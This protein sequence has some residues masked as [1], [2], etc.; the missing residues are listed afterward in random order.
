MSSIKST[1]ICAEVWPIGTVSCLKPIGAMSSSLALVQSSGVHMRRSVA[2]RGRFVL[3]ANRGYV[4]ESAIVSSNLSVAGILEL[5]SICV[6]AWP[7]G[8]KLSCFKPIEAIPSRPEKVFMASRGLRPSP[9]WGILCGAGRAWSRSGLHFVEFKTMS[10]PPGKLVDR[11]QPPPS[12]GCRSSA[13]P[14]P[15][16][17]K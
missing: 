9:S 15:N 8:T 13:R 14:A 5:T 12:N 4:L 2:T 6:E 7:I 16:G 10:T 3:E 11:S 17:S 1:S